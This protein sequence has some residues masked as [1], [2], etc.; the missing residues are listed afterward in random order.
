MDWVYHL[1]DQFL[2]GIPERLESLL[3]WIPA[4]FN[5]IFPGQTEEHM[6]IKWSNMT[7]WQNLFMEVASYQGILGVTPESIGVQ[8]DK[9]TVDLD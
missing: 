7:S 6:S 3:R 1:G 5:G 9:Q 8:L 2:S 4:H